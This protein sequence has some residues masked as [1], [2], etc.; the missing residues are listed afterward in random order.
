L[1]EL[2]PKDNENI[3]PFLGD[4]LPV[5]SEPQGFPP[6][7]M[8]PC[9]ECLRA[10]P[11]TRVTC[12]YCAAPFPFSEKTANLQKP[13]LRPLEKWEQGY[14]CILLPMSRD[15][16]ADESLMEAGNLLKLTAD[17]LKRITA[18]GTLLPLARAAAFD[19]SSLVCHRLKAL[20][21][22]TL[23]VPDKD[24]GMEQSPPMRVRAAEID[25][26]G[27]AMYQVAGDEGVNIPWTD[28]SLFVAG[29]LVVKRVEM[30]ERK[31]GRAES[32]ILD[33]SEFF[34]DEAVV[35]IYRKE[36]NGNYRIVA[37]RF[38]FSC[39][40]NRKR[41]L[42]SENF[43][44]LLELLWEHAPQAVYDHSYNSL[45]KALDPVWPSEQQTESRGLRRERPGKYSVGTVI[46]INNEAQFS[47]YSRLQH[48]LQ[49]N[50]AINLD[51][52]T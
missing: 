15:D 31:G 21:I 51:E 28:L 45:R 12:I 22:R 25:E 42:A 40:G 18:A 41:L 23:V 50:P 49:R 13:S 14:N 4:D 16:L 1:E 52:E 32:Q 38:D 34:T 11:P 27:I 30:Q 9:E 36:Q 20:G 24:L 35:D 43:F 3:L 5:S 7:E 26:T 47:R 10:N 19:E 48:Y 37:N 29:R 44:V 8:V 46:E 17:Q 2:L 39:L 6:E 33:A